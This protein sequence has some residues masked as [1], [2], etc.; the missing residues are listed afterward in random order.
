LPCA[1]HALEPDLIADSAALVIVAVPR[2]DGLVSSTILRLSTVVPVNEPVPL[3]YLIWQKK[4]Q[5]TTVRGKGSG[6]FQ[7]RDSAATFGGRRRALEKAAR[8]AHARRPPPPAAA[9]PTPA[10]G[11]P[12]APPPGSLPAPPPPMPKRPL[13]L[14]LLVLPVLP[15]LQRSGDQWLN[16]P[17]LPLLRRPGAQAP[18]APP[19]PVAPPACSNPFT[20]C[21]AP[22]SPYSSRSAVLVPCPPHSSCSS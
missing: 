5:P 20:W 9:L 14:L 22:C 1:C 17:V 2:P 8:M 18:P 15:L 16:L 21:P 13:S 3:I 10:T 7:G 19:P 12:G 11:R 4:K 6:I